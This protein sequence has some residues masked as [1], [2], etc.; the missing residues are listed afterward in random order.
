MYCNLNIELCNI[1]NKKCDLNF[2]MINQLK[3]NLD[4]ASKLV[5]AAKNL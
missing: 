1:I 3:V 4:T 2:D 5:E